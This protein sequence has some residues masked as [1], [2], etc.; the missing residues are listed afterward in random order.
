MASVSGKIRIGEASAACGKIGARQRGPIYIFYLWMI[1]FAAV[2]TVLG[3]AADRWA[4]YKAP[5]DFWLIGLWLGIIVYAL[6]GRKIG[7]WRFRKRL[8]G[9]GTPLDMPMRMEISAEALVYELA[10]VYHRAKWSAISELFHAKGYWIFLVQSTPWFAADRFFTSEEDKKVFLREAL[11]HM[12]ED[13]RQRSP[14]AVK[15]IEAGAAGF[16]TSLN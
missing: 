9:K 7:V 13:A 8:T 1:V 5:I 11:S 16:N 12:T 3:Y 4:A 14:D 15:F 2:G 10:D 6:I